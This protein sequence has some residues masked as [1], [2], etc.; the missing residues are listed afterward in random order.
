MENENELYDYLYNE[1]N[2]F[3]N[4]NNDLKILTKI[5]IYFIENQIINKNEDENLKN[6]SL[7]LFYSKIINSDINYI[8]S[9]FILF[10]IK[11][12]FINSIDENISIFIDI[13]FLN[14]IQEFELQNKINY[15]KLN[16]KDINLNLIF[17]L[18]N[19][20]K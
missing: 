8:I 16:I 13:K 7:K 10:N 5:I 2:K 12:E 20:Y 14:L 3:E 4:N 6:S 9:F 19:T 17:T 1:Y 18:L 15:D 11:S